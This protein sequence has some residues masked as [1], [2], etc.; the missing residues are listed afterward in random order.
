MPCA[1]HQSI[2]T[3]T[4]DL[5]LY[6]NMALGCNASL[7]SLAHV[8]DQTGAGELDDTNSIMQVFDSCTEPCDIA[9][10]SKNVASHL[11]QV[12]SWQGASAR[13]LQCR[14]QA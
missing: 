5:I 3:C 9:G 11:W 2:L 6:A 13:T 4:Q 7:H 14:G 10:S 8:Y 12:S 1:T